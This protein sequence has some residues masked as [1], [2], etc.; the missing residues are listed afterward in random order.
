[1]TDSIAD[2]QLQVNKKRADKAGGWVLARKII[3][4]LSLV[5]FL[6]F[7]LMT[8]RDGWPPD[9]INIPMRLDP[10]LMLANLLAS[11]TFR[12]ASTL[13]LFTMLLTLVFGRA[14]CGWIC[15]LGTTLDLFSLRR[16]R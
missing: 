14:W 13:G 11:R 12:I 6:A 16:A 9:V 7:F 3:Q 4:Y 8:K 2:S 5:I 10:M 1:M 15:P